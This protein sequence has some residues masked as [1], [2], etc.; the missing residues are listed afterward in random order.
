MQVPHMGGAA[1][2]QLGNVRTLHLLILGGILLG[3]GFLVLQGTRQSPGG[4]KVPA[5]LV[6]DTPALT[7]PPE[8]PVVDVYEH[9]NGYVYLPHRYPRVC[10]N[11]I[12][13]VINYGHATLRLPHVKDMTWLTS[14][15]SEASL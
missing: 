14:P 3:A 7:I 15:P 11:E 10:G 8:Q 13:A 9:R 6:E 12:T 1:A 2:K 4:V 5:A